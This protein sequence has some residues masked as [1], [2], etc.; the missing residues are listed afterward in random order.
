MG[1]DSQTMA[2]WLP[3]FSDEEDKFRKVE[4]SIKIRIICVRT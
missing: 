2:Q 3:L 4:I 1:C